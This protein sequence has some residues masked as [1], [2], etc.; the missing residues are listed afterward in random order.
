MSQNKRIVAKDGRNCPMCEYYDDKAVSMMGI[1]AGWYKDDFMGKGS[2]L[3]ICDHVIP[4]GWEYVLQTAIDT[5]SE[6]LKDLKRRK[7]LAMKAI[8]DQEEEV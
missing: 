6:I 7:R 3:T 5:Q 8:K 4:D 2:P 1:K